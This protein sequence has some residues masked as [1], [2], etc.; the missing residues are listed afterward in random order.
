MEGAHSWKR[1]ESGQETGTWERGQDLWGGC[2]G[3]SGPQDL[4]VET[5]PGL[6]VMGRGDGLGG[7]ADT[8]KLCLLGVNRG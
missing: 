7:A 5:P 8:Q 4:G 2:C 6:R 3:L 1:E